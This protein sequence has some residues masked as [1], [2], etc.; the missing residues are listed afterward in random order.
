MLKC[1]VL[2]LAYVFENCRKTCMTYYGLDPANYLTV[3]GLAWDAMLLKTGV[4]LGQNT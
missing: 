2:L 1:G 3:Q 4:E